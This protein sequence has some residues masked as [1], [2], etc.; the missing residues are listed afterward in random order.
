MQLKGEEVASTGALYTHFP[1]K[2]TNNGEVMKIKEKLSIILTLAFV[3]SA[4][5]GGGGG[6]GSGNSTN[7]IPLNAA[8]FPNVAGN[9]SFNTKDVSYSCTDGSSGTNTPI[10][11]N[12]TVSQTD[13]TLT[14]TQTGSTGT[15]P[16][17]TVTSITAAAGNVQKNAQF[18]INQSATATSTLIPGTL[19][20]TYNTT[21]TFTTTGWSGTYK[22]SLYSAAY[23]ATCN[24]TTTFTGDKIAAALSALTKQNLEY[25]R[26]NLPLDIYDSFSILGSSMGNY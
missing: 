7:T 9:Y 5:G 6:N 2:I 11:L 24:F 19:S 15:I 16:G 18:I 12:F 25:I 22:Y 3:M 13:N 21:G 1:K 17:F 23:N 14:L 26:Q 10:A 4:C 20:V 8:G